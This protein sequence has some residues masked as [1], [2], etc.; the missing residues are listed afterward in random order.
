[1]NVFAKHPPWYAA[2]LAFGCTECGSC[3][4]GPEEGYVWVTD[5]E[6]ATIAEHLSLTEKQMRR[7]Y[8][9][10]VYGRMSLIEGHNNDCI[11]LRP[12][13]KGTKDC[14]VY[15]VRPSQCRTWPFWPSNLR[16]PDAWAIAHMRCGGMNRG[17]LHTC[18]EID[19]QRNA[20]RE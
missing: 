8:V 12:N 15:S 18:D 13:N 3:C 6:I 16:S 5:A 10:A 14:S 1:M 11:F 9:R 7:K 19:A 17:K 4:A 2:G 20:T